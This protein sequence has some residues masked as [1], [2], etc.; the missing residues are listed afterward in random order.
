M[1]VPPTIKKLQPMFKSLG[2]D[3]LSEFV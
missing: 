3:I 1:K 2:E